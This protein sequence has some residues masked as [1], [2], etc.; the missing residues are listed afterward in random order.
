MHHH[1]WIGL[2]VIFA[3]M[4]P[5]AIGVWIAIRSSRENTD[6]DPNRPPGRRFRSFGGFSSE[7]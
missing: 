3:S 1:H 7:P 5:V 2:T 4:V 6:A